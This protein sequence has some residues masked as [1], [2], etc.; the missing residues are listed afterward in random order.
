MFRTM[1]GKS[2]L[3]LVAA[4]AVVACAGE[5]PQL[6]KA[7]A[8]INTDDLLEHIKVLSAD[9]YEGRLPSSAGEEKTVEN[10]RTALDENKQLRETIRK[11]REKLE[12]T[13]GE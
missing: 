1:S 12:K 10:E 11:L 8:T 5:D 9:E 6:E 7:L 4:V 2:L 13:H 3:A